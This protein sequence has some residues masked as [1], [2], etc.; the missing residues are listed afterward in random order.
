MPA[1]TTPGVYVSE[2]QLSN[3]VQP[4]T[5]ISA[6]AFFGTAERGPTTA[7]LVNDWS[8]YKQLFGDLDDDYDLGYAVF[9]YFNNGG[10]SAYVNR[11][12]DETAT[13]ASEVHPFYPNGTG[14]ASASL[15]TATAISEGTW[16]NNI[17]VA[18]LAGD[19]DPSASSF[20][21]FTTVVYL[22]GTEVERWPELSIDPNNN[23]YVAT[24][25]NNYS[26]YIRVSSVNTS[27]S[28]N[29]SLEYVTV[30]QS[31]AGAIQG[32]VAD[33]D[34]TAALTNIDT[35]EGNLVLNAVGQTSSTVVTALITKATTR[36]D[37]FV[38]IDPS[39]SDTTLSEIQAT[40]ANYSGL[41]G[42]GYAAHYAPMLEMIDP[43]K[44]GPGAIRTT[45]PC[46]A[47]AGI[48]VRTEVEQTVAQTPAG[49]TADVRGALGVSIKLS[50]SNIG[51]LYNGTPQVNSFKAIPGAGVVVWGGRTLS[52]L[53]PSKYISVRR[54]L[55][56]LKYALKDLTQYAVFEPNDERL[57]NSITLQVSSFLG[58]FWRSGGL[59]GDTAGNAFYVTCDSTNNTVS[60]I[61]AGEVHIDVGV[62][63]TYPAE[64]IV[65]NL[66]QWAGGANTAD[67]VS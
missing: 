10:R 44:T 63:L 29:A 49:Y 52:K 47:I 30:A 14:E 22:S 9:H 4:S 56:Y 67:S 11:V 35:V 20:G 57:W 51:T 39:E 41:S 7:T 54:T 27:A 5:G 38:L 46:G 34:Y 1:Y 40:A 32:T 65:I 48:M 33:S 36:G 53:D 66:S 45:Y 50:D 64:F 12:V 31:L 23:R 17:T 61:D 62:A 58:N 60:T 26:R 15:L 42:G 8:S 28:A 59:K 25:I 13:S 43:A 55:N 6:A 24:V 3:L 37:S 2:S 21:T 19:V 16:G 18:T